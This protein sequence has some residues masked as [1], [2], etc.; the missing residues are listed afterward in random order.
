M[1]WGSVSSLAITITWVWVCAPVEII[2]L[3]L[4][5]ALTAKPTDIFIVVKSFELLSELPCFFDDAC[6]LG[7]SAHRVDGG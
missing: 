7:L 5:V 4:I 6:F 2:G 1:Q 3:L